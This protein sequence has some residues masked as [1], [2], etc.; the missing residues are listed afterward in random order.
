MKK[1]DMHIHV[2]DG[3]T[4]DSK[5][6]KIIEKGIN[7]GID[8]FLLLDHGDR[9]S[10]KKHGRL[11]D[12]NIPTFFKT[13][14]QLNVDNITILKAIDVDFSYDKDFRNNV[15]NMINKHDFDYVIGSVHSM[16]HLGEDG[17]YQAIIDLLNTYPIDIIGH[18][19]MN[20]HY[21]NHIEKFKTIMT[22]CQKRNILIEINTSKRSI[23]T[24][25]QFQFMHSLMKEYGVKYTIGS[26]AHEV[27][28]IAANYE[29]INDCFNKEEYFLYGK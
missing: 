19:R 22:I 20:E 18:I 28:E 3:I 8:T 26:D 10:P 4:D 2:K 7:K 27:D 15:I 13:V 23:W 21:L 5:L 11:T 16:F 12:E 14:E 17:Y 25:D 6:E 1:C 29:L 24:K 9:I